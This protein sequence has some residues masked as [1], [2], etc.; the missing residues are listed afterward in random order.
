MNDKGTAGIEH[1]FS[2]VFAHYSSDHFRI[3]S[4]H[5]F[6]RYCH[7]APSPHVTYLRYRKPPY[8]EI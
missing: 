3:T 8:G 6:P 7:M 4:V 2:G 5:H 1:F